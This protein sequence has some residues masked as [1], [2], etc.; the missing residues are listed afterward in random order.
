ML[1]EAEDEQER[2]WLESAELNEGISRAMQDFHR[3]E[4]AKAKAPEAAVVEVGQKA[5]QRW[6]KI[7]KSLSRKASG[8]VDRGADLLNAAKTR[9]AEAQAARAERQTQRKQAARASRRRRAERPK[10]CDGPPPA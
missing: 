5:A 3:Q 8:L 10:A 1:R 7:R 2:L 6:Q 9:H 4:Q